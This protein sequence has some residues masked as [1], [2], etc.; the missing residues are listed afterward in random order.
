M[1]DKSQTFC[2]MSG[3]VTSVSCH[4][5]ETEWFFLFFPTP[6]ACFEEKFATQCMPFIN[7]TEHK[8]S[9]LVAAV[10]SSV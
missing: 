5:C 8:L 4:S 6:E 10:V 9:I 3:P 2:Q 7:K 1:L